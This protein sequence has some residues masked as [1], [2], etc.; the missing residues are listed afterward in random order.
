MDYDRE[1]KQERS[2]PVQGRVN[3]VDL[4]NLDKYFVS[5]GQGVKTMSRLLSWGI[6]LVVEV[7]DRNEALVDKF[8]SLS[9]AGI[10]LNQRGLYQPG[11]RNR[12]IKKF[13]NA[14]TFENLRTAGQ[15]P[16]DHV[17]RQYKTMHNE[18]SVE[19]FV[20]GVSPGVVS[21]DDVEMAKKMIAQVKKE[22]EVLRQGMSEEE[23]AEYDKIREEEVREK[24]NAPVDLEEMK[25][26][27]QIVR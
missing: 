8:E 14:L 24:E 5:Q 4:A 21:Q 23:L 6:S 16:E 27:G 15:H 7:L 20:G 1:V 18:N 26:L 2:V 22:K 13:A 19:P 11:V 3:L 12:G 10:Y 17:P 9:E 25:K